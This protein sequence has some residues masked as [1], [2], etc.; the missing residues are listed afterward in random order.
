MAI[1][2]LKEPEKWPGWLVRF[3][4]WLM[5]PFGVSLDYANRYPRQSIGRYLREVEYKEFYF[6][7]LYLSVGESLKK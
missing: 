4:I 7:A 5:K 2:E 1:L 3:A 6:G